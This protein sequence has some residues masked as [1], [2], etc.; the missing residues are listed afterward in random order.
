MADFTSRQIRAFLLVARHRSFSKAAEAMFMT[1]SALSVSIREL[2]TQLGFRLFDRTTRHVALTRHGQE[3]L[4]VALAGLEQFDAAVSRICRS[5]TKGNQSVSLGATPSVAADILPQAIKEFHSIQPALR[6]E[7]F[8]G[9]TSTIM[10]RI[11]S[12]K[13]D[14]GLGVFL[15]PPAGIRRTP[16]FRFTLMLIR[17]DTDPAFRPAST[18]W[19]AIK[20][21]TLISLPPVNPTQQLINRRLV[22]AGVV[23]QHNVVLNYLATVIALVEADEGV[24]VIPSF[25]TPACAKRKIVMSRLTNPVVNLDFYQVVDRGRRLPSGA[26]DFT[27]FLKRY[28]ARW[29]GRAGV[30]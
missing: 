15:K 16:F 22:R 8:E 25:A 6:I 23:F 30:L 19:S 27:S 12:G 28:I 2:E 9:D 3:L 24:A 14:M 11:Q 4:P 29:A 7:L 17:A 5:A 10:Q 26:E 21:P 13:L 1:P 18:T 20:G